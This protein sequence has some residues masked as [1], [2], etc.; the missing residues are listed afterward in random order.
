[1][2]NALFLMPV[3]ELF[4][5]LGFVYLAK[6]PDWQALRYLPL[7]L[8]VCLVIWIAIKQGDAIKPKQAASLSFWIALLL[9][10]GFQLAG[11]VFPGLAKDVDILSMSNFV[12]LSLIAV[13]AWIGHAGLLTAVHCL[14]NK[15]DAP[16]V[17]HTL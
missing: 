2:P 9:V 5:L 8:A 10:V 3:F 6:I 14:R 12:R 16:R 15:R 11:L 17:T 4:G 1:M 13:G 7:V